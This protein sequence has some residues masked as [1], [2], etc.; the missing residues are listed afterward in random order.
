M[1]LLINWLISALAVL[2]VAYILPGVNVDSFTTALVVALVLGIVNA[3]LKPILVIL[4]LPITILTL[5]LFTFVINALLIMLTSKLVPGFMVDGFLWA[6]IFSVAL[7]VVNSF[8]HQ[9]TK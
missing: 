1:A 9:I 5:G 6:L 7:S 3:I 8:L 2:S 4:T